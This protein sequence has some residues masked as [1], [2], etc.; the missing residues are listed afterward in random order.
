MTRVLIDTNIILDIAL[1][2]SI[3]YESSSYI[4]NLIDRS[5][6]NAFITATTVTDIYYIVQ[7]QTNHQ[8]A[9]QFIK[10]LTLFI[11]IVGVDKEIILL[12][13]EMK[14]VD[15]EDAVQT[16]AAEINSMDIIVTRNK[17][18]FKD[19]GLKIMDPYELKKIFL[20]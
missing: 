13:F 15:F 4:F 5:I 7:K 2:R 8:I 9:L 20:T 11:D 14:T 18:D 6:I 16:K 12:A 10:E 1:K 19:T 3:H 17:K